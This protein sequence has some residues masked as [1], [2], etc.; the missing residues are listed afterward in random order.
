MK[1]ASRK[2]LDHIR[3]SEE[4]RTSAYKD[5]AGVW[6]IGYGHT[7]GVRRGDKISK[8]EAEQLLQEDLLPVEGFIRTIPQIKTQGQ[9]DA[10]VDFA[11]NLGIKKLKSSTLLKKIRKGAKVEDIQRQIMRWIYAAGKVQKGLITRR[12]WEANRYEELY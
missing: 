10:L 5:I 12:K 4:L 8:K 9:F 3:Q 1:K 6:T 11:F 2:L 7:K